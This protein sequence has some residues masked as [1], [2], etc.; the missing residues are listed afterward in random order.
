MRRNTYDMTPLHNQVI[1]GRIEIA[2][3]LLDAGALAGALDYRGWTPLKWVEDPPWGVSP[4][5]EEMVAL[6]KEAMAAEMEDNNPE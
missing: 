2:R 4:A 6:L 5:S 1:H 3:L